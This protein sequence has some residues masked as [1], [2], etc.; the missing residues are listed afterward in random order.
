MRRKKR[1]RLEDYEALSFS[2]DRSRLTPGQ[3]VFK[4]LAAWRQGRRTGQE[5][6]ND[7]DEEDFPH[8][9]ITDGEYP[10]HDEAEEDATD[11]SED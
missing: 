1:A 6:S 10:G 9:S 7:D 5:S 8:D 11:D 2:S 3:R 4:N